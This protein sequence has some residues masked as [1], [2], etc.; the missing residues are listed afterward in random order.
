MFG[1]SLQQAIDLYLSP[2]ADV[3]HKCD[4]IG[5]YGKDE[6]FPLDIIE[7]AVKSGHYHLC[8]RAIEA[9][10]ERFVEIDTLMRWVVDGD[11]H[12]RAAAMAA[13]SNGKYKSKAYQ[14]LIIPFII[15]GLRDTDSTVVR[16]ALRACQDMP[17]P[18]EEL[19]CLIN[20]PSYS[21]SVEQALKGRDVY[22]QLI[23]PK[24]ADKDIQRKYRTAQQR[25]EK[26]RKD[27]NEA[28]ER[29]LA[30]N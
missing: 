14:N 7:Q 26:F 4:I 5:E 24:T 27:I 8:E 30:I 6:K 10:S 23:D 21:L 13:C 22:I 20:I 29:F 25:I 17:I 3:H 18:L 15:R 2:H 12:L 9:L 11:Y 16:Q 1:V 19:E 28:M